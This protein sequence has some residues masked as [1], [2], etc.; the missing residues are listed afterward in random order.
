MFKPEETL[1][2]FFLCIAGDPDPFIFKC[3]FYFGLQGLTTDN[4]ATA[5]RGILNGIRQKVGYDLFD[6]FVIGLHTYAIF[7]CYDENMFWRQL[8]HLFCYEANKLYQ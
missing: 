3:D 2:D 4:D 6:P 1:K 7:T 5:I 8:L